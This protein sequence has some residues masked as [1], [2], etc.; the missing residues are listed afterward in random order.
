[1]PFLGTVGVLIAKSWPSWDDQA[2][3][4]GL[5]FVLLMAGLAAP[6][7]LLVASGCILYLWRHKVL[8]VTQVVRWGVLVA[9]SALAFLWFMERAAW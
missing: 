3:S 5:V 6:L 7:G 4:S 1:M 2:V 9:I 8:T